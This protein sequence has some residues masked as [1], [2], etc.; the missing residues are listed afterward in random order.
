MQLRMTERT[1]T[2]SD[3]TDADIADMRH[4][5][6]TDDEIYDIGAITAFFAMSNRLANMSSLRPNAEFHGM[7]RNEIAQ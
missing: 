6:F 4:K 5:G 7:G 3:V 2:Y 1:A